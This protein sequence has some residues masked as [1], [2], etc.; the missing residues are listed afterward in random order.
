M[1]FAEANAAVGQL[2]SNSSAVILDASDLLLRYANNVIKYVVIHFDTFTIM[3][4]WKAL[5]HVLYRS[6]ILHTI[7]HSAQPQG[8]QICHHSVHCHD[9]A[10][11]WK[12]MHVLSLLFY[13]PIHRFFS[14][15]RTEP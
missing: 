14:P 3:A 10:Q 13:T 15:S 5:L 12:K 7:Y 8:G 1:D 6:R 2:L 9:S 11:T 4:K